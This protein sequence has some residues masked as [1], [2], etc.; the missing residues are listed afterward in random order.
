MIADDTE[1]KIERGA[2]DLVVH[3]FG[4]HWADDPVGQLVQSR[5]ALGPDGLFLGVLFGGE[6]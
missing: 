6:P 5:L 1:L 4:L 2:Q 3:A